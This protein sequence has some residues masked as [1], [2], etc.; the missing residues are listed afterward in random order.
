MSTLT[1][2]KIEEF[3]YD[4]ISELRKQ[5]IPILTDFKDVFGGIKY[6]TSKKKTN[7]DDDIKENEDEDE[8]D[9]YTSENSVGD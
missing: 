3:F 7:I 1:Q 8:E 5:N 9:S 4:I 6:S 2:E